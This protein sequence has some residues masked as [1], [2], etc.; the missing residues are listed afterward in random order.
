MK[1]F[2]FSILVSVALLMIVGIM[3]IDSTMADD[4]IHKF[5]RKRDK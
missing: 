2:L 5:D 3:E 1:R 4:V